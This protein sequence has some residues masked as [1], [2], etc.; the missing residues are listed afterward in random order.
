MPRLE[1]YDKLD[2]DVLLDENP[3]RFAGKRTV[4]TELFSISEPTV[5]RYQS[6]GAIFVLA[7]HDKAG[8]V[9]QNLH[10]GGGGE[11]SYLLDAPGDYFLRV[12]GSTTWRI[13]LDKPVNN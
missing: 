1:C 10:I 7:V 3:P 6:D 2:L 8:E 9:V 13:W 4:K 11:D 5:I 12:N